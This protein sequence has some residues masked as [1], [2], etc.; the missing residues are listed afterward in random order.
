MQRGDIVS[1]CLPLLAQSIPAA[2]TSEE[3]EDD[4]A[5]ISGVKKL[6]DPN[7][8]ALRRVAASSAMYRGGAGGNQTSLSLPLLSLFGLD[9]CALSVSL[10][11][12]VSLIYVSLSLFLSS[13]LCLSVCPL[14]ISVSL[15]LCFCLC[16]SA[17]HSYLSRSFA[18]RRRRC[19]FR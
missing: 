14:C 9:L 13:S 19:S 2:L 15:S 3:I 17:Q 5:V 1:E 10:Y 12:C 6:R 4:I 16:L 8:M 11:L 18:Y 7:G